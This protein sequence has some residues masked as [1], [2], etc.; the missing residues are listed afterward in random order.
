MAYLAKEIEESKDIELS[1]LW[2][3]A[4]ILFNQYHFDNIDMGLLATLRTAIKAMRHRISKISELAME[5]RY[6]LQFITSQFDL[7]DTTQADTQSN[8]TENTRDVRA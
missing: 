6:M 3:R 7:E 4:I 2:I 1:M 8:G 5:N